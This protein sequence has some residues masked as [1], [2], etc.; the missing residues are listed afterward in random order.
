LGFGDDLDDAFHGF[1]W[2]GGVG[3]SVLL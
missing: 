2:G 1:V 3:R